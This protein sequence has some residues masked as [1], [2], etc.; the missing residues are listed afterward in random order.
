[1]AK[2]PV[3]SQVSGVE[4]NA[5]IANAETKVLFQLTESK[6]T[7]PTEKDVRHA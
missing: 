6:S 5:V 3:L 2:A 4:A 1:M 7:N